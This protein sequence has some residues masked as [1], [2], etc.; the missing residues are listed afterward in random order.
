M[1]NLFDD[2]QHILIQLDSDEDGD[3]FYKNCDEYINLPAFQL[4]YIYLKDVAKTVVIE[5]GYIDAII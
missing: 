3:N 2:E 1:I 4:I 5:R